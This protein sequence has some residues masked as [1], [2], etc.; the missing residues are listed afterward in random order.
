VIS[1]FRCL[2]LFLLAAGA[3]QADEPYTWKNVTV[4]GGGFSPGIVFSPAEK[5]LAYLRTDIGGAYRWDDRAKRWMPLEDGIDRGAYM[6]IESIAPDPADP[7]IVYLAAGTRDAA[8]ILRSRDRGTHWQIFPTLFK[9]GGNEA[10]RGMGER[11]AVD[12]CDTSLLYFGSRDDG[13]ERSADAGAS[14]SPVASFPL[15]ALGIRPGGHAPNAGLSFVILVPRGEKKNTP[16]RTIVVASADP[17]AQHL[18]RSDDAGARWTPVAGEPRANLLP[19]KAAFDG[20][21]ALYIAY[22][23]NIGPNGATDGAVFKLDVAS[24]RMTDITPDRDTKR[25]PGGYMA[26]DADRA[27]PGT[28]VVATLNRYHPKD[29]LWRTTD[30]GATWKS[31]GE[32]SHR[33]V[34]ATPYLVWGRGN[35]EADFGWWIAALA[36]DPF[37]S[38]HVAYTT[39]ATVYATDEL[40]NA[41]AGKPL[42]WKPW[43][44]GVEETAILA[45]TSPVSGP[46]LVSGFGDIAGFVHDDL[47][48]SPDM[49]FTDPIFSNT[50]TID[51]AGM[52]P[53]VLVRSG[54]AAPRA[55]GYSPTL[56]Y[57]LDSGKSWAPLVAPPLKG[58]N[59]KGEIEI[60]HYDADGDAAIVASADGTAFVA[61]TPVPF[62]TRDRGK[63]W[64]ALSMLP[65][66]AHVVADRVDPNRFYALDFVKGMILASGDGGASFA[67]LGTTGLA[68][69]PHADWPTRREAQWPLIATPGIAGD[70]WFRT[71]AGR[72]LH[73]ADGGRSFRE[74]VTY[75]NI[76]ALGFGKAPTA[77]TY[78]ALFSFGWKGQAR[79][80][81][82]SDDIGRSWTRI[83]DD[84]HQYGRRFRSICGDPRIFGRVYLG[85]D[86]RG[87]FYGDPVR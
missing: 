68:V 32:V 75:M 79:G 35:A 12:P 58:T 30:G 54:T 61:M 59:E 28:A 26:I 84:A 34:S 70:L 40:R 64:T 55:K 85:T 73:S 69:D 37:D 78:P 20:K 48:R 63:T 86:G 24:N 6:E 62:L 74:V 23:D 51:Y 49:L 43:V 31:L 52:A 2:G 80:V 44:A 71:G 45:L 41:D 67:A 27:H 76:E 47:D 42:V 82:R 66:W 5:G 81:W 83:N 25:P 19:V 4:G 60:R 15:K 39:G 7:D 11:L 13:L 8:A 29:T 46:H 50:N 56:A 57:S 53:N 1:A 10:G 21:N 65:M 22:S 14:W 18:F 33:D 16:T 87:L 38:D 36:I 17:G 9:M 3:A 72:L 77:S